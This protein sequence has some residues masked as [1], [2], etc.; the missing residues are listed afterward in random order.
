MVG[1]KGGRKRGIDERVQR[2]RKRDEGG[3]WDVG[4]GEVRDEWRKKR[5]RVEEERGK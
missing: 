2:G 4:E 1:R 5:G 3:N